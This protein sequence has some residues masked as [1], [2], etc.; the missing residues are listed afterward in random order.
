MR[1][2]FLFA[3]FLV[4]FLVAFSLVAIADN[5]SPLPTQAPTIVAPEPTP[6]PEPPTVDEMELIFL[7]TWVLSGGCGWLT[8]KYLENYPPGWFTNAVPKR[9]QFIAA[10]MSASLA[11]FALLSLM[12]LGV[13]D[14]PTDFVTWFNAVAPVLMF[15]AGTAKFAH[16]Q[17]TLESGG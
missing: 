12:L 10:A 1:F 9:K 6:L 13:K 5:H 3:G 4:W 8:F 15:G 14:T 17:A 2:R 11:L 16:G 7:L